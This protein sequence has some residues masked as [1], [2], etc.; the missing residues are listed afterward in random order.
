MK[1]HHVVGIIAG[2]CGIGLTVDR[3]LSGTITGWANIIDAVV[4]F[5]LLS[6]VAL[7][8]FFKDR[9]PSQLSQ[10]RIPTSWGLVVI[11]GILL[12][13]SVALDYFR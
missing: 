2:I 12:F 10:R 4:T 8:T 7:S 13:C 3:V 1:R 11:V 9:L 5:I 6:V